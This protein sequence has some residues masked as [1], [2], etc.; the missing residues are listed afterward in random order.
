MTAG[1]DSVGL[2][3]PAHPLALELLREAGIPLAAPSAN[4][5]TQLSPTS[6]EHVREGLGD[7]VDL[8]LD[9]GP[10]QVGIESTV[11]SVVDGAPVLLRPGMISKAKLEEVVGPVLSAGEALDGEAHAAPGMHR[12]HYSPKTPLRMGVPESGD[13]GYLWH[14][15]PSPLAVMEKCLP[16]E[17]ER[18]AAGLYEALHEMDRAEVVAI[19][20]EPLPSGAEWDAIRDRL[21]RA[22]EQLSSFHRNRRD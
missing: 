6:A 2:R 14:S 15:V 3:V 13:C 20:V 19:W 10:C 11:V 4:R 16:C 21:G 18:Y 9:G 1:L 8:V 7:A 17:P 5:F 12:K 22:A